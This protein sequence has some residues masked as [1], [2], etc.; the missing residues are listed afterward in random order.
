MPDFERVV[1]D[2]KIDIAK[3]HGQCMGKS[4]DYWEGYKKGKSV[5][6]WHI[7]I[8]ICVVYFAIAMLGHFST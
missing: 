3:D 6:R 8:A 4:A 7:F 1:D 2:L 5:A